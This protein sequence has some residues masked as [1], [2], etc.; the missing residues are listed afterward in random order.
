[1]DYEII[2]TSNHLQSKPWSRTKMKSLYP[3]CFALL[4][5]A[6]SQESGNSPTDL[7]NTFIGTGGHGHT[8]PGASMPFGM[9]QLSPDTRLDGWDGCG[10]YHYTDNIIFGFSHTHL[11]GTGVSDYG[12]I[13]FMPTTGELK[14]HNGTETEGDLGYSAHFSHSTEEARP[15]YYKVH[16]EEPDIDVELTVSERSGIHR[17]NFNGNGPRQVL[18]DLAHRDMVLESSIKLVNENEVEGMRRSKAWAE[19]QLVYFVARSDRPITGLAIQSDGKAIDADFAVGTDIKA[20]MLFDPEESSELNLK[21][22][23]SATSLEAARENLEAEIGAKS[24]D[25][26][27]QSAETAWA[28]ELGRIEI[29]GGTQEEQR[30]FY[31]ALYHSYLAPNLF[32]NVDGSYRG[33]DLKTHQ[34]KGKQYTVFSLWDTFRGT[35]PL[36]TITQRERTQEFLNTFLRQYEVGGQLP[37]WEL[38]G[39]YTGCMIGYHS[40]PVIVDAYFK[41]IT[42][43]DEEQMLEAMLASAEQDHLGLDAYKKHG[44]ISSD[45]ESES[46]SK[47][48]EYAYDDWCIAIY[49]EAIGKQDIVSR[50][51]ERAQSYKNLY[52]PSNGFLHAR[53]NGSWSGPFVPSE[54]NFNYT[55]ANAWQYNFFTPQDVNGH[56]ELMGGGGNFVKQLDALFSAESATTGREQ[57]DIT[58]LI[59]QYAHGNEPSHHMAYLYSYVGKP[60]KTQEL[61]RRIMRNLYA[62]APDGLSG[63]EDCGQMS[64]WY[65]LSA[66]GFYPVTPG[67]DIYVLGSPLFDEASINLE[68]GKQFTIKAV[69]NASGNV[70][71]GSAKLN[72]HK[73]DRSFIQHEEIMA[74][75]LLEFE[76]SN[77][78]NYERG[79]AAEN[80]PVARIAKEHGIVP[81]PFLVSAGRTFTDSMLVIPGSALKEVQFMQRRSGEKEFK[82]WEQTVL[83]END[84]IW[85]YAEVPDGKKSMPV[86]GVFHRMDDK[87]QLELL[88]SYANE[89]NAGG[90]NA[91]VDGLRGGDDF[92]TGMWQGYRE[93]LELVVDLGEEMPISQVYLSCLQD[94]KS[95]IWMPKEVSV[96]ISSDG[97]HF[98]ELG[99]ATPKTADNLYGGTHEDIGLS[100]PPTKTRYVRVQ[101]AQYGV[102]PPWH[103][104]ADGE[105]WLFVDEVLI[106]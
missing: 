64:S 18:I 33:T 17:Y 82:K 83:T 46:V 99:S 54:V 6:C 7:V 32:S 57:V 20:A 48:L 84:S 72:G 81:A 4:L 59:G 41:G 104:G 19:D 92:R 34:G 86:L 74:G 60:W 87:R 14:F 70:Y 11:S 42:D 85:I 12:D 49:A 27:A 78:P 31:S 91:L 95:W 45:A 53:L 98:L 2:Q 94:V 62:D 93:D 13:L 88:S 58:G 102:C 3:I 24:F 15:G 73:L 30:I 89:Y 9:M 38:A 37:V 28:K 44:Y 96:A 23:I 35:H 67:S 16:L 26:V 8:Y 97:E 63:N 105:S 5:A 55:E 21:V 69:N 66:M 10:G 40:I 61:V 77:E 65:V 79:V 76:M 43:F 36:F 51:F 100:F 25:E 22:G 50:Y 103:I 106:Q 1:M 90:R 47:T 101:A 56:I 68:N 52:D 75:G 29:K 71:I 80:R 39:N